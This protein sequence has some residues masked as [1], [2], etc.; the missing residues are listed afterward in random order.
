MHAVLILHVVPLIEIHQDIATN[1]QQ[2]TMSE[3]VAQE[4]GN[5]TRRLQFQTLV[6]PLITKCLNLT[7]LL[8]QKRMVCSPR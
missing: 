2:V 8:I 4:T 7:E 3:V 6:I 1:I 5:A